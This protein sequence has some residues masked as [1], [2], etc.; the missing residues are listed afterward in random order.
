MDRSV[1]LTLAVPRPSSRRE[2]RAGGRS[3]PGAGGLAGA[4]A[5]GE[6]MGWR[7][8]A[9]FVLASCA[10]VAVRLSAEYVIPFRIRR[11]R[12]TASDGE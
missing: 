9:P 8:V 6:V 3:E 10:T 11:A 5:V 2:A 7:V 4:G 1:G 12:T